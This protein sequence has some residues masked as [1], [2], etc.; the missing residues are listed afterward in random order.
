M[1]WT[2]RGG[3]TE[4]VGEG[5]RGR[6]RAGDQGEGQAAGPV[7]VPS[8]RGGPNAPSAAQLPA[9]GR[10]GADPLPRGAGEGCGPGEERGHTRRPAGIRFLKSEP[11]TRFHW[12]SRCRLHTCPGP[13]FCARTDQVGRVA[14]A[15]AGCVPPRLGPCKRPFNAV[16]DRTGPTGRP[17]DSPRGRGAGIR[18]GARPRGQA[19]LWGRPVRAEVSAPQ[20]GSQARIS[21]FPRPGET[22]SRRRKLGPPPTPGL[23][24]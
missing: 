20:H 11:R 22:Q 1:P 7:S 24:L 14:G 17:R 9:P 10:S 4:R 12:A 13:A 23:C 5:R 8:S 6:A 19:G 3:G 15:V 16:E 18:G 2:L 21:R